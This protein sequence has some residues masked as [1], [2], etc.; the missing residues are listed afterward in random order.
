[1]S[2][3]G[4]IGGSQ[5]QRAVLFMVASEERQAFNVNKMNQGQLFGIW[6]R[7]NMQDQIFISGDIL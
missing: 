1:M 2:G 6:H 3:W 5:G 7:L 4:G